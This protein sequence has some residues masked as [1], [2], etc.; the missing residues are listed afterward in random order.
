MACS[1]PPPEYP[2]L[3]QFFSASRLRDLTALQRIA[4]VVFEPREQGVVT[5]FTITGV[6]RRQDGGR[7]VKDVTITAP[8]RALSGEIVR[9]TLVLTLEPVDGDWKVTAARPALE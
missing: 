2:I 9:K 7:E 8:V 1:I 6:A 3:Q 4:T 5:E